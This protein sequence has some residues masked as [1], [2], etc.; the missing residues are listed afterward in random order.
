MYARK[1]LY[2]GPNVEF[3]QIPDRILEKLGFNET[4]QPY[5]DTPAADEAVA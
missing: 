4:T 5:S 2:L 3:Y 1:A